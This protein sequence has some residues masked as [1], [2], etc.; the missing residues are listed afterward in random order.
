MLLKT[1][2]RTQTLLRFESTRKMPVEKL[3][4]N[5]LLS[6]LEL[7]VFLRKIFGKQKLKKNE[8]DFY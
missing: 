7:L 4:G 2:F 6:S 5:D 1:L 8:M 3:K